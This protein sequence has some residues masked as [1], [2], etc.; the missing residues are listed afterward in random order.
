MEWNE[1]EGG[2]R[3]TLERVV[4]ACVVLKTVTTRSFDN[5]A[6]GSG[7]ATGFVVDK[8]RGIVLTNR[9]AHRGGEGDGAGRND[10]SDGEEMHS[11]EESSSEELT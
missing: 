4:P 6:A 10:R 7:F 8:T 1:P 9:Y 11:K 5:D 3:T 2:W